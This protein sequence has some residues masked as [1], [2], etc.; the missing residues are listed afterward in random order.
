MALRIVAFLSRSESDGTRVI[1]NFQIAIE[2]FLSTAMEH[3]T[4]F[5]SMM[6]PVN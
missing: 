4:L 5:K 3:L 1:F 6:P 2:T